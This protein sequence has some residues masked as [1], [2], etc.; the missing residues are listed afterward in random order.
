MLTGEKKFERKL[1]RTVPSSLGRGG[2][3][4]VFHLLVDYRGGFTAGAHACLGEGEKESEPYI[5]PPLLLN[6]PR[7]MTMATIHAREVFFAAFGVFC[8]GSTA[9]LIGP[10]YVLQ[11]LQRVEQSRVDG[12]VSGADCEW[13]EDFFDIEFGLFLLPSPCG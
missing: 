5:S 13:T 10:A 12:H 7:R 8:G 4:G 11:R 9:P 6:P 1:C 2:E 3:V